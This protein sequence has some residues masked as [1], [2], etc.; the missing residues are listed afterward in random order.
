MDIEYP[1]VNNFS[2]MNNP[3]K[4]TYHSSIPQPQPFSQNHQTPYEPTPSNQPYRVNQPYQLNYGYSNVSN[5]SSGSYQSNNH[6][7]RNGGGYQFSQYHMSSNYT[8]HYSNH[9]EQLL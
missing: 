3:V 2:S 9:D 1:K 6:S 4:Y 5:S 7:N 8:P